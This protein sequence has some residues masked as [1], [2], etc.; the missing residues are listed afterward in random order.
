MEIFSIHKLKNIGAEIGKT[1]FN[2][3]YS[4]IEEIKFTRIR[5]GHT[6]L[7]HSHFLTGDEPLICAN[8]NVI[9]SI[10]HILLV[11]PRFYNERKNHFG[12]SVISIKKLLNRK[13]QDENK[14][15]IDFMKSINL[16]T[17]I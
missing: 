9:Y 8:C 7:T 13:N 10:K 17:E 2:T 1:N 5:L 15:V 14:S 16:F 12:N 3:F 4:R 6:R 11:C